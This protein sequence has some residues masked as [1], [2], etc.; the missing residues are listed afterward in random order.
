MET[1]GRR[2]FLKLNTEF[3]ILV[4]AG[5][6]IVFTFLKS[7]FLNGLIAGGLFGGVNFYLLVIAISMFLYP[8]VRKIPA[9][10]IVILK[11]LVLYGGLAFL[12]IKMKLNP[13]GFLAGFGIYI[14]LMMLSAIFYLRRLKDA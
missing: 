9:Y 11:S 4:G 14:M 13:Q 8:G 2:L 3:I 7:S 1:N 5:G 10:G 6:I 12:L